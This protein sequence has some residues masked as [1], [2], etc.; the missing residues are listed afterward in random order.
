MR[1]PH[2]QRDDTSRR[3]AVE[4]L[5]MTELF[6][7]LTGR[8]IATVN[9]SLQELVLLE[10]AE[11]IDVRIGLDDDVPEFVLVEAEHFLL[12][13]LL[14]VDVLHRVAHLIDADRTAN[15]IDFECRKLLDERFGSRELPAV[16]LN[17]VIDHMGSR[18]VEL[19]IVRRYLTEARE[20]LFL[21]GCYF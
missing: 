16:V 8:I 11:L 3:P 20:M 14:N 1:A 10:L 4:P 6:A 13:D 19:R 18:V 2:G 15:G 21:V 17:D 7:E 5:A 12:L 9:G